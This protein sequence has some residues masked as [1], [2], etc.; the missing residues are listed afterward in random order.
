MPLVTVVKSSGIDRSQTEAVDFHPTLLKRRYVE[1]LKQEPT[2]KLSG[3]KQKDIVQED[4]N[5]GVVKTLAIRQRKILVTGPTSQVGMPVALGLASTN[6]VWGIARFSNEK[7]RK[8]LEA[9]GVTCI[10][11][12]LATTDFTDLPD[13]FDY[14]LNFAVARG[15]DGDW[16]RDIAANAESVGLLMAR[17]SKVQAFLHCSTAG[18][19]QYRGPQHA[20]LET[21]AQ[22][23][24]NHDPI[25]L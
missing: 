21:D 4:L 3:V 8:R 6:D 24:I 19:Y 5:G 2:G 25:K 14:V 18:V 1:M 20:L 7:V 23:V 10:S 13:D 16:D 12:D 9:A 22:I 11:S 15:G 17:L